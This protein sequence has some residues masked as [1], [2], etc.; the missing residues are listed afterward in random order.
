MKDPDWVDAFDVFLQLVK[1]LNGSVLHVDRTA[2]KVMYGFM[3]VHEAEYSFNPTTS[4]RNLH[5]KITHR[6]R[7]LY[8]NA[9][10]R[11]SNHA[12]PKGE[13]S[14]RLLNRLAST[15]VDEPWV[16]WFVTLRMQHLEKL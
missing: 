14:W 11:L 8:A 13:V 7:T 4:E 2:F 5:R 3:L 9:E 15:Y 1:R 10:A 12:G 16:L 6:I